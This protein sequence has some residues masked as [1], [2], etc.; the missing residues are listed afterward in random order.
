MQYYTFVFHPLSVGILFI[1]ECQ[2][3][4]FI[5]Q[6][7]AIQVHHPDIQKN[8][9]PLFDQKKIDLSCMYLEQIQSS[10]VWVMYKNKS[11]KLISWITG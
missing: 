5:N 11:L 6:R 7:F 2:I 9:F 8:L 3:I 1:G 10:Q 4:M